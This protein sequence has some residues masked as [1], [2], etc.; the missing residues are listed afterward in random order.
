MSVIELGSTPFRIVKKLGAGTSSIVYEALHIERNEAVALKVFESRFTED[1][2]FR[3]R[4]RRESEAL[5]SLHHPN[6]TRFHQL[7]Q[8]GETSF[9]ELEL[10]RGPTL[11][12]WMKAHPCESYCGLLEPRIWLL[13]QIARALGA[14]HEAGIVHRDLKPDNIMVSED[15]EIKLTDFGLARIP[16]VRQTI[17]QAGHLVGSLA[18]MAPEV[19]KGEKAS[20]TSD[21]FSFGVLAYELLSGQHPFVN[22]SA[23]RVIQAITEKAVT[24]CH[25]RN[26]VVPAAIS[27]LISRCLE[28]DPAARAKSVWEAEAVLMG[29]LL[30][31]ELLPFAKR[32]TSESFESRDNIK[33]GLSEALSVKHKYLK[34]TLD[35]ELKKTVFRQGEFVRHLNEFAALFPNDPDVQFYLDAIR[36]RSRNGLRLGSAVSRSLGLVLRDRNRIRIRIFAIFAGVLALIV[37]IIGLIDIDGTLFSRESGQSKPRRFNEPSRSFADPATSESLTAKDSDKKYLPVDK[38]ADKPVNIEARVETEAE[39]KISVRKAA[40]GGAKA[41]SGTKARS[42]ASPRKAKH[43]ESTGKLIVL[44]DPDVKVFVDGRRLSTNQLRGIQLPV[45][46]HQVLMEKEGFLPIEESIE[47]GAGKT[48]KINTQGRQP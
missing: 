14:A 43:I 31:S 34:D 30:V 9:L 28:I 33:N 15:G 41:S 11:T 42:G 40:Y 1:E 24:P 29:H 32:L 10:I 8:A 35:L 2:G 4:I 17:T 38:S 5:K 22:Q 45:G 12:Q 46:L 21:V 3:V 36:D 16:N 47:I 48:I 7:W 20:F 6:I 39:T 18:Y 25:L 19:L 37:G 26:T 23:Q 44:V 13:A 27:D